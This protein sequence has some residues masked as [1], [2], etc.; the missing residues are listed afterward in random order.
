MEVLVHGT[1]VKYENVTIPDDPSFIKHIPLQVIV[2]ATVI[3]QDGTVLEGDFTF[4][5]EGFEPSFEH[6]EMRIRGLFGGC[7]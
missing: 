3:F 4:K 5:A 6:A 2:D 7:E 1:K